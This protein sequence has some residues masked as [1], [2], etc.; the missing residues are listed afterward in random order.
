MTKRV[1]FSAGKISNLKWKCTE[2][3]TR[4]E[5]GEEGE[6]VV[7]AEVEEEAE[8]EVAAVGVSD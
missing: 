6:D 2:W 1:A 4:D 3:W 7:E 8:G 5:V